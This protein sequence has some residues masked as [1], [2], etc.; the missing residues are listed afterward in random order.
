MQPGQS[1]DAN[2]LRFAMRTADGLKSTM[3]MSMGI[4]MSCGDE[5]IISVEKR[6]DY[7]QV[8]HVVEPLAPS[9]N[10]R[11]EAIASSLEKASK[12]A[13]YPFFPSRSGPY[14]ACCIGH[15]LPCQSPVNMKGY[16]LHLSLICVLL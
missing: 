9:V 16:L 4:P 6:T 8:N 1:N 2:R 3:K 15:R 10:L 5:D 7:S 13:G 12:D 11:V 14:A